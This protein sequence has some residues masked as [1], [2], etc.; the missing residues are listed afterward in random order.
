L[1]S[2]WAKSGSPSDLS[3]SG[4]LSGGR[5][6][7]EL[8]YMSI[9]KVGCNSRFGDESPARVSIILVWEGGPTNE[10]RVML[11]IVGAKCGRRA[12]GCDRVW[13]SFVGSR[14]RG[15]GI[16]WGRTGTPSQL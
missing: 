16:D 1:I 7:G 4:S 14:Q 8:R 9:D 11:H 15:G 13:S 2:R 10:P 5:P 12:A 6:N 3:G